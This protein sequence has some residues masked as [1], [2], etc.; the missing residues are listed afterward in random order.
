MTRGPSR[1]Q[2]WNTTDWE[3]NLQTDGITDQDEY[4]RKD[5]YNRKIPEERGKTQM[6]GLDQRSFIRGMIT[7]FCECVAGGCKRLALSPPL[8]H[9]DYERISPEAYELIG[10]HGLVHYH[11]E[12]LDRPA[13]TRFEWILIAGRQETID[14]Y[15]AL[16]RQGYSPVESLEPFYDL[17]SYRPEE[18]IHTGYDAYRDFF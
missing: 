7:A 14:A 8:R 17:L 16:R 2:K 9:A 6:T 18:S 12:N 10:K 13:D 4:Y 1:R 11:E 5:R 15:L 3:N